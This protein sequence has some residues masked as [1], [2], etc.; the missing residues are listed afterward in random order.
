MRRGRRGLRGRRATT[1]RLLKARRG[2]L[3]SGRGGYRGAGTHPKARI[4]HRALTGGGVA[5][6]RG[7]DGGVHFPTQGGFQGLRHFSG[8][9]K[10]IIRVFCQ[11]FLKPGFNFGRNIRQG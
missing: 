2:S 1:S 11:N 10:T 3:L 4:Y 5:T 6:L 8:G 9:G 7:L